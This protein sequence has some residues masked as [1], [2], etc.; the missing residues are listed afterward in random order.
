MLIISRFY[1]FKKIKK[2]LHSKLV[3]YIVNKVVS[4]TVISCLWAAVEIRLEKIFPPHILSLFPFFLRCVLPLSHYQLMPAVSEISSHVR[5]LL[6]TSFLDQGH[7]VV[8]CPQIICM[9][10]LEWL[11][12]NPWSWQRAFHIFSYP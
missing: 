1:V 11:S 6:Q 7:I 3:S 12:L 5:S 4:L 8:G 10:A 2:N 9:Q